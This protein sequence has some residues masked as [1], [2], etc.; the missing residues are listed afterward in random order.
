MSN[1]SM[2]AMYVIGAVESNHN[3]SAVN[4][5]D[6]ITLGMMQWYGDRAYGLLKRGSTADV[7]GWNAFKAADP[8]L[9]G[10]VDANS[11]A[12][13]GYYVNDNDANSWI[14][15]TQRAENHQ[16]QQ[17]Q[18]DDDYNNYSQVCD[19][20][21]IPATNI[22]QRIFFMTMYH[23]GPVY[24]FQ[25]LNTCGPMATLDN[26]H[27]TCLNNGV[28]GIYTTR[29]NTAY[30]MLKNWDGQSA[31]PDFGQVSE[32]TV[33]GGNQ[34]PPTNNAAKPAQPISVQQ[35]GDQLVVRV[36]DQ[37]TTA[38]KST[39]QL[40]QAGTIKGTS[41]GSGQT[42]GGTPPAPPGTGGASDN[43]QKVLAWISSR[44]GKFAY[45]QGPGRLN[46]DQSGYTDCSGLIWNA[47]HFA[48][49]LDIGTWTGAQ[50]GNGTK[51][52][53]SD[54]PNMSLVKAGDIMLINWSYYDPSYDHV[55][56]FSDNGT[57][58]WSHGGPGN[59]PHGFTFA[60][61]SAAAHDW[62]IRRIIT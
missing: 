58:L 48:I 44:E 40:W 56:M 10:A 54:N 31:P 49:G 50:V 55:E 13:N 12:W 32:G 9:A 15:W 5:G 19:Q 29:Y 57:W 59:G 36:G 1:Q 60:D 28:L 39:A 2:Y 23:Q 35:F 43:V 42:G 45:G 14:T 52:T 27:D 34:A 17:A 41:N 26:F 61:E 18:W 47:C 6:P 21:G 46:A 25:V 37:V 3:W 7:D 22:Q 51:L 20:N 4:R 11:V 24:A 8:A 33:S 38:Y 30:D 62:Q 53:D 16:F